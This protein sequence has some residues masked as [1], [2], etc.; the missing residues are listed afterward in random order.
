M[1]LRTEPAHGVTVP[2]SSGRRRM[3][4]NGIQY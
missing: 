3:I 1:A 4:E 2:V